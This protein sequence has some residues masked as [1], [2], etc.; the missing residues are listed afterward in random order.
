MKQ[1]NGCESSFL[2]IKYT[3]TLFFIIISDIIPLYSEEIYM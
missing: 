3:E 2:F 1:H